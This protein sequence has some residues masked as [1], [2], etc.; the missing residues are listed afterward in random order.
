MSL[1]Y[2]R[3]LGTF[4]YVIRGAAEVGKQGTDNGH[5]ERAFFK[6]LKLLGLGK[7]IGLKFWGSFWLFPAKLLTLFWHCESLVHGKV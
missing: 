6:N 2:L 5:P 3:I 4:K 7:Q 1:N